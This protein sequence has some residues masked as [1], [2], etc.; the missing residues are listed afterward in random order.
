M[1]IGV[2]S[3]RAVENRRIFVVDTDEII[4]AAL[5][6]MLHDENEAHELESVEAAL[7]KATDWPPDLIL[8]GQS[9]L[10][11]EGL[12]ALTRLTTALP[13]AQVLL[14]GSAADP[15][16]SEALAGGAHALIP[17]PLKLEAV[18]KAVDQALGRS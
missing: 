10:Q 5:Q 6:F 3:A 1:Q 8:L 11:S 12:A 17:V 7:V 15:I 2:E 18:R 4:R 13:G 9:L 16:L 14:V